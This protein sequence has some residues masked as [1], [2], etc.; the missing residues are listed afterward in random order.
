MSDFLT[1]LFIIL[2]TFFYIAWFS[3]YVSKFRFDFWPGLEPDVDGGVED[4]D[5]GEGE[6]VVG[7][8][9]HDRVVP[10]GLRQQVN[11]A[12][13]VPFQHVREVPETL[14]V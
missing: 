4:A 14:I 11:L 13:E 9:R 10:A 6:E 12:I 5:D 2:I 7:S 3:V 1:F 8:A